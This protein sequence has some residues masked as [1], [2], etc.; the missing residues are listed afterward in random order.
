MITK[1][2]NTYSTL[3][4]LG[5]LS[6]A[7]KNLKF[8]KRSVEASVIEKI[9]NLITAELDPDLAEQASQLAVTAAP[10]V[11]PMTMQQKTT[12]RRQMKR[13]KGRPKIWV[14]C[15]KP[16]KQMTHGKSHKAMWMSTCRYKMQSGKLRGQER[17]I[18]LV[19]GRDAHTRPKQIMRHGKKVRWC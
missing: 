6:D 18:K 14:C 16:V 1:L 11:K 19:V 17:S 7:V 12:M 5:D 10:T 13:H 3:L 8:A 9:S 2:A 15:T 4:A